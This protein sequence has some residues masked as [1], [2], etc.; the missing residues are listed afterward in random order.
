[1]SIHSYKLYKVRSCCTLSRQHAVV[2]CHN[3]FTKMDRLLFSAVLLSCCT[4]PEK[5]TCGSSR[6]SANNVL[7]Q[8][9][10]SDS[11]KQQQSSDPTGRD[12]P[13]VSCLVVPLLLC[14][15]LTSSLSLCRIGT[16]GIAVQV[17]GSNWPKP[18]FT[19]LITGLCRFSVSSLLKERPFVLAEVKLTEYRT[20]VYL[21]LT[22]L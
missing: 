22:I 17:V 10:R 8:F 3:H 4:V 19:L 13:L 11:P 6:V 15:T 18:H 9:K 7:N 5:P 21:R 12:P 14:L 16:A 2:K 20:I 1:M